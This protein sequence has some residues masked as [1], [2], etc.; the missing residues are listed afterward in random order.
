MKTAAKF[1]TYAVAGVL[2][3][4]VASAAKAEITVVPCVPPYTKSQ[5]K[6]HVYTRP[7]GKVKWAN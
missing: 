3:F 4:G 6:A 2:A 7:R 5:Q 1:A